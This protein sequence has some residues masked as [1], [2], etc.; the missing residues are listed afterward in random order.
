MHILETPRGPLR[1]SYVF[2]PGGAS[3]SEEYY[4]KDRSDAERHLSLPMPVFGPSAAEDFAKAQAAVGEAGIVEA[5]LGLNPAGAAAELFGSETF[6]LMTVTDRD[7]I[8]ALCQ[9]RMEIILR[10]I[11]WLHQQSIGPFFDLEGYEYLVPPLH[12]PRDFQE[13]CVR[14]DKPIIDLI[15]ELGGRVHVHCHGKVGSVFDGFLE[16]GADV[17]HPF[18]PPPMGDITAKAAKAAARGRMCLEGNIQIADLYE[19]TPEEIRRQTQALIA[20][21]FD[22]RRG[23]IV[24]PTS[25]PYIPGK[26]EECLAQF[27]AMVQTVLEWQPC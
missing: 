11:R 18:E 16:L 5:I 26:G 23:L 27:K 15:H 9:R 6:A 4:L 14:Y 19:R 7:I 22:D 8:H 2:A 24:C 20:D 10:M 21:C 1:R 25:S 17:L 13:F 12:G 3:Y